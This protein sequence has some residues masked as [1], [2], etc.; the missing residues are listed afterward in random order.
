MKKL[1][2]VKVNISKV[3]KRGL[4]TIRVGSKTTTKWF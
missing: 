3:G 2:L 1:K 4:L